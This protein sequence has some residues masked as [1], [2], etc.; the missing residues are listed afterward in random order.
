MDASGRELLGALSAKYESN[1]NPATVS[2]GRGDA[3]GVSYGLYQ[4]ATA[5]GTPE[6][7]VTWIAATDPEAFSSLRPYPPGSP[8]FGAAWKAVAARDPA[9]FG[10][11]QH[12]FVCVSYYDPAVRQ[13]EAALPGLGVASRSKALNDVVWSTAVQHGVG[14]AVRVFQKAL[15]ERPPTQVGDEALMRA[16]YAERG[17][18]GATGTLIHFASCSPDVQRG[19]AQ[20]FQAE[21]ADALIALGTEQAA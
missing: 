10:E 8:E 21:L 4:F 17:R 12:E 13:L 2:T 19:V 16:V 1:G 11:A 15:G 6:R 3:G 9:R 20:R 14:G 5:A 7:F 18:R